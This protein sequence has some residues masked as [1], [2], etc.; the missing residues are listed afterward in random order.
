MDLVGHATNLSQPL[1]KP[2]KSLEFQC[3]YS[4]LVTGTVY[5][6]SR[7]VSRIILVLLIPQYSVGKYE[8]TIVF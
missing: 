8:A 3:F 1:P 6:Y 7:H 5:K 2:P 4:R